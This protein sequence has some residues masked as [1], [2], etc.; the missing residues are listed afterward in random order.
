MDKGFKDIWLWVVFGGTAILMLINAI[1]QGAE[2]S[3][4][5]YQLRMLKYQIRQEMVFISEY[6]CR[7]GKK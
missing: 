2:I 5:K 3:E 4:I 1:W 6:Y 7:Y